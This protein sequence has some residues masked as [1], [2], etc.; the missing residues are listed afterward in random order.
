MKIV[1]IRHG[2]AEEL[3]A[4]SKSGRDDAS[5][6]LTKDGRKKMARAAEG[7]AKITPTVDLIAT[8]PLIRAVQTGEIIAK[9]YD[10][11]RTVQIAALS[12]RKPPANLIEWLNAHP[13]DSTVAL[14]GH[15]PHLGTVIGWLTT[16]LQESFVV[17]KKGGAALIEVET[18]VAPGRGK[19]H[20]LLKP[21]ELRKLR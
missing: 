3:E 12:P 18:P 11:T 19:L 21:S 8:S 20:W 4:S 1:I 15:E 17:L 14:V 16:G 9:T 13:P 5:R 2:I 6:N 7:L 10:G